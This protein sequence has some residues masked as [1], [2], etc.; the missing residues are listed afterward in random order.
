MPIA[1]ALISGLSALLSGASKHDL[2]N[3]QEHVMFPFELYLEKPWGPENVTIQVL[4]FIEDYH[5]RVPVVKT[6][7]LVFSI[8]RI[9]R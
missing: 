6:D 4:K 5:K 9:M 7:F 8:D 3:V 2:S 1:K